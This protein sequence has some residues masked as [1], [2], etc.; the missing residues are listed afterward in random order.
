MIFCSNSTRILVSTNRSNTLNTILNISALSDKK[1]DVSSLLSPPITK[2]LF[3][4]GFSF[5]AYLQLL[6]FKDNPLANPNIYHLK[7]SPLPH[8]HLSITS[9]SLCNFLRLIILRLYSPPHLPLIIMSTTLPHR[10]IHVVLSEIAKNYLV[11]FLHSFL[12][13]HLNSNT[14]AQLAHDKDLVC[15]L[16]ITQVQCIF[17]SSGKFLD[18]CQTIGNASLINHNQTRGAE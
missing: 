10:S 14:F 5:L 7:L 17:V 3:Q 18:T 15:I 4:F 8:F 2:D 1:A 16:G 13:P 12:R 11:V 9:S 6:C